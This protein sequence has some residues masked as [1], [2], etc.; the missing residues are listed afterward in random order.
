MNAKRWLLLSLNHRSDHVIREYVAKSWIMSRLCGG[1]IIEPLNSN[2]KDLH[3]LSPS[4]P[5]TLPNVLSWEI[6]YLIVRR[7]IKR[8]Y[9]S[10]LSSGS[11]SACPPLPAFALHLSLPAG[12]PHG[13]IHGQTAVVVVIAADSW[14]IEW[15]M[16]QANTCTNRKGL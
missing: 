10:S 1:H 12:S 11:S 3:R 4:Y 5:A 15:W 13:W 9:I 7:P 6:K 2:H 8:G 14:W 16:L